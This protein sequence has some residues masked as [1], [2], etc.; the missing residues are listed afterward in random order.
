MCEANVL[1]STAWRIQFPIHILG[2]WSN[3]VWWKCNP[4]QTE[5]NLSWVYL[6]SIIGL[7][8]IVGVLSLMNNHFF[9]WSCL[10]L[11]IWEDITLVNI[12]LLAVALKLWTF[13]LVL[14][15]HFI[16]SMQRR[17]VRINKNEATVFSL[18]EARTVI[19]K[20]LHD[21]CVE[22]M[23]W[24]LCYGCIFFVSAQRSKKELAK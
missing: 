20:S 19:D 9:L 6:G 17:K 21:T 15:T 22:K 5:H 13:S 18:R 8:D 2:I 10:H 11:V 4:I 16:I 24:V 12:S 3:S 1:K 14:V 23:F 7:W